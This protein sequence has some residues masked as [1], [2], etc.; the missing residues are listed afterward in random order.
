MHI[1]LFEHICIDWTLKILVSDDGCTVKSLGALDFVVNKDIEGKMYYQFFDK[2]HPLSIKIFPNQ[3][4]NTN[5]FS[6][7]LEEAR[8]DAILLLRVI[9]FLQSLNDVKKLKITD[10]KSRKESIA[11]IKS[12]KLFQF[13]ER[14][15]SLVRALAFIQCKTGQIVR[16]PENPESFNEL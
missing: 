1:Y 9:E 3:N 15:L 13:E 10:T 4:T 6:L 7:T 14:L 8:G 5:S 11:D 2:N 16:Y 12:D